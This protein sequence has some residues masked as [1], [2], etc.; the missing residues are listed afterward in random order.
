MAGCYG[1]EPED[2]YF[3]G[4][5]FRYL[6]ERDMTYECGK[7]YRG[8]DDSDDEDEIEATRRM[9]DAMAAGV[10]HIT[11]EDVPQ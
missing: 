6:E 5:L 3:E 10:V 7:P 1:N 4:M 9:E 2:R 8:E 11:C